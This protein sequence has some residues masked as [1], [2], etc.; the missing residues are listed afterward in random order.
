MLANTWEKKLHYTIS[1]VWI[2]FRKCNCEVKL[3]LGEGI[4]VSY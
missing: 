2:I 4:L 3:K 1:V